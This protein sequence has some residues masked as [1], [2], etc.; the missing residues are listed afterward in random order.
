MTA[1]SKF[2]DRGLWAQDEAEKYL[3]VRSEKPSFAYHRY[4]DSRSARRGIA[5]QPADFLVGYLGFAYHIEV[6]ETKEKRLALAK[7]SQYGK[8]KL[9]DWAG[10]RTLVL[11]Y[12]SELNDWV[13]LTRS[14][15]FE[16]DEVPKSFKLEGLAS[17]PSAA[18]ALESF[19]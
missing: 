8:L 11:V 5:S 9:F 4:P 12:R 3:K 14:D 15:L 17:Y 16:H 19:L 10:F 1:R 13:V 6:K 2:A 18:Y 7:I